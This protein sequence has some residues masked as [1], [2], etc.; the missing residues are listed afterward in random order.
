MPDQTPRNLVQPE[1]LDPATLPLAP[2]DGLYVHIPFCFHKCHYCDFYSIT[3]Q[4]PERM[5][6][7]VDL[8]LREADQ[9]VKARPPESLRPRT[10]FFGGGTPSLLP[11][12]AMS[13]LLV[14]LGDRFDLSQ[15]DEWTVEVNPA[16]ADETYCRMLRAHGVNR[17]SFGAQ[18]FDTSELAT[19]ERHHDPIDVPRSVELA[20]RAGFERLNLDLIYA[21]PG[22]DL[23]SWSRSLEQAIALRTGH[24]SCYGLTYEPNTPMAVKKRLG[25]LKAADESLELSMLH[26][27]RRRL[28]Q[29]GLPPYE[30]SNYAEPGEECRH[31]LMYWTGGNYLSLGPSAASHVQGWRWRNRPHLGEWEAAVEAGALP[32]IDVEHLSPE[33][34]AGELAMLMLRLAAGI[35]YSIFSARTGRDPRDLFRTQIDQLQTVGLLH[36]GEH[37]VRLTESGIDV[38]DAIAAEFLP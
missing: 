22:Q 29:A 19:L 3:R 23:D 1:R 4:T 9:W 35:D 7:F 11:I 36:V 37:A 21:I 6:H 15:V 32:V 13:R 20:R 24:L 34:R 28:S 8:L 2:I 25:V 17:L 5:D 10:I 12:H 30:I 14:G 27:T 38:A 33:R 26:H 18:S 16:T 31:N